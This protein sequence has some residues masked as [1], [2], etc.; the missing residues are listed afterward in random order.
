MTVDVY[1]EFTGSSF[2][3]T[4]VRDTQTVATHAA[5]TWPVHAP[6]PILLES[7]TTDIRVAGDYTLT[8]DGD[9]FATVLGVA[10]ATNGVVFTPAAPV[11]LAAGDHT[12][13]LT[14]AAG[15]VLWYNRGNLGGVPPSV[16]GGTGKDFL[17]WGFWAEPGTATFVHGSVTFKLED[18]TLVSQIPP[19]SLSSGTFTA[20][21]WTVTFDVDVYLMGLLKRTSL[22]DAAYAFTVDGNAVDTVNHNLTGNVDELWCPPA[23]MLLAAGG[24]VFKIQPSAPKRVNYDSGTTQ[25]PVGTGAAH[26]T[27]WSVWAESVGNKVPSRI[28]FRLPMPPNSPT[29]LTVTDIGNDTLTLNWDAPTDGG[30]VL[31]FQ[32]RL[33][34]GA[35]VDVTPG[36]TFHVFTGLDLGTEYL[37]AVRT[38]GLDGTSD[39]E[40]V[41]ESTTSDVPLG[42]YRVLLSLGTD[43]YDVTRGQAADD[44]GL[45]LPLTL[46]WAAPTG[47]TLPTQ[48]DATLLTF[49][50]VAPSPTHALVAQ[51]VEGAEV[52]CDIF[53]TG[54]G[55]S[56]QSFDGT[57]TQATGQLVRRGVDPDGDPD[58]ELWD[59]VVTVYATDV[60]PLAS[61]Q[62]GW[63]ANWPQEDVLARLERIATEAGLTTD[64]GT[65]DT[66]ANTDANYGLSDAQLPARPKGQ[67]ITALAAVKSVLRYAA[68]W[69]GAADEY[70]RWVFGLD[71]S[72]ATLYLRVAWRW[73]GDTGDVAYPLNGDLVYASGRWNRLTGRQAPTWAN[74]D[75]TT[76]GTPDGNPG[77]VVRTGYIDIADGA[78]TDSDAARDA[79]G[80]F[81]ALAADFLVLEG[82]ASGQ[83]RYDAYLDPSPVSR[84][85]SNGGIAQVVPV[86]PVVISPLGAELDVNGVGYLA[87]LLAA[88]KLVI[89]PDGD[90]YLELALRPELPPATPL[91]D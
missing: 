68:A 62:V 65:L 59:W 39:V 33:D 66:E 52:R 75:G 42:Y 70:G 41:T 31:G 23:P 18:R 12:F 24:R 37:L 8:V 53:A 3:F 80:G 32:V 34:A 1:P 74:V 51:A 35:W 77:A 7:F 58:V 91:P 17:G 78:P 21:T 86:R 10:A 87:G 60:N 13:Q 14:N 25:N 11:E 4:V 73:P 40:S 50:I 64:Y 54:S 79:Y 19:D 46:G 28:F 67:A 69:G 47:E 57:V 81:T 84:W 36:D 88:A 71:P 55:P 27:G 85:V 61:R 72:T 16:P 48:P 22:A 44:Y 2:D 5:Q 20:Q 45:R 43:E 38:V 49:E 90:F 29:N 76:Y 89:P 9:V 82:W 6:S 26:T 30:P 83:L 63:S 56:W 15:A